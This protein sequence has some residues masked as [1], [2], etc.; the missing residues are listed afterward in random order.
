MT[1]M[2]APLIARTTSSLIK[3][4]ASALMNTISGKGQ[5]GGILRY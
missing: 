4:M 5:E 2:A 1:P 3:P